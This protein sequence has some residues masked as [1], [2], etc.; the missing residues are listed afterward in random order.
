[1]CIGFSDGKQVSSDWL[2]VI[3]LVNAG[4]CGFCVLYEEIKISKLGY[5]LTLQ[6]KQCS[7][8]VIEVF[9]G[10]PI[11]LI[12]RTQIVFPHSLQH[13]FVHNSYWH[14]LVGTWKL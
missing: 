1:M 8:T 3:Y 4:Y 6:L 13:W 7:P 5:I 9:W 2:H 14:P 11:Y 12:G 10:L